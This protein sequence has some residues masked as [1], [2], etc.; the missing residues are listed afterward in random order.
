[1][2]FNPFHPMSIKML[3][4][5][6]WFGNVLKGYYSYRSRLVS[7]LYDLSD[8]RY[9]I[10]SEDW[11]QVMT[12]ISGALEVFDL[13]SWFPS[14]VM[15]DLQDRGYHI[16]PFVIEP[17][18][19]YSSPI[20]YPYAKIGPN[21]HRVDRGVSSIINVP[22]SRMEFPVHAESVAYVE[23]TVECVLYPE[24]SLEYQDRTYK[25]KGST[26][27]NDYVFV[28]VVERDNGVFFRAF[29][30][31]TSEDKD[32]EFQF[33]FEV[34][35][36]SF[37]SFPRNSW[38][39]IVYPYNCQSLVD[40]IRVEDFVHEFL[41]LYINAPETNDLKYELDDSVIYEEKREIKVEESYLYKQLS[42]QGDTGAQSRIYGS[43]CHF[44]KLKVDSGVVFEREGASS[45]IHE[46]CR[47]CP[48][49]VTEDVVYVSSLDNFQCKKATLCSYQ[50]ECWVC[51]QRVSYKGLQSSFFVHQECVDCDC[52]LFV[53]LKQLKD[54]VTCKC[55]LK[56]N[57]DI[58]NSRF[59]DKRHI[60]KF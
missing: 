3:K 38:G 34:Q 33:F 28:R 21:C 25:F 52:G 23:I 44:C 16:E 31:R 39:A 54:K 27:Q 60:V 57:Y 35:G 59:K 19:I 17:L 42:L 15:L 7:F 1:M 29:R 49:G 46:T 5:A 58:V 43:Y 2:Q 14:N 26:L 6:E 36:L 12:T 56:K 37:L 24:D 47:M 51:H 13:V 10:Y 55:Q 41:P 22:Y 18:I 48:C 45:W 9:R 30:K 53:Q 50:R 8:K 20:E 32:K 4:T 40:I 11:R